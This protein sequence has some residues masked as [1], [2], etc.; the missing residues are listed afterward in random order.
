MSFWPA[1]TASQV[2][3]GVSV[4][5]FVGSV[6]AGIYS[7]LRGN[8]VD[9]KVAELRRDFERRDLLPANAERYQ[10]LYRELVPLLGKTADPMAVSQKL[11]QLRGMLNSL[12]SY[13]NEGE[14]RTVKV[15]MGHLNL[16]EK[17]PTAQSHFQALLHD[18]AALSVELEILVERVKWN[19]QS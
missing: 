17:E 13:L 18:A 1:D 19:S 4:L 9:R 10:E 2:A 8:T 15:M 11:G 3:D 16:I 5:A 7:K 6:V 14:K 12:D